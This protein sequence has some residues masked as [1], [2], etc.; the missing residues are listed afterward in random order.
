MEVKMENELIISQKI[1][2]VVFFTGGKIDPI[3]AEIEKKA[4]EIA[5]KGD[6]ATTSGRKVF[7]SAAYKVSRSKTLLDNMRKE[8][9]ADWKKKKEAVDKTWRGIEESLDDLRDRVR[10]P[11]TEWEAAE[12]A[13]EEKERIE[14]E[15]KEEQERIEA[16]LNRL[17]GIALIE[18]DLWKRQREIEAKEAEIKRIEDERKAKE[19]AARLAEERAIAEEAEA[20]AKAER[21]ERIR[22]EAEEKAKREAQE[23]LERAERA[24]AEAIEREKA[25]IMRAQVEAE[26]AEKRRI[27][28]EK[29]AKED[30]ERAIREAQEAERQRLEMIQRAKAAEEACKKA[31]AER[32]S[33]DKAHRAK[34]ENEAKKDLIALEFPLSDAELIVKAISEGK[35]RHVRI[36]Y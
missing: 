24:K 31:E 30:R 26:L 7:A 34:I 15:L 19:E 28:A 29:K 5:E 25:A 33:R 21:E 32:I 27:E 20:K 12:K 16:E 10:Q 18:H 2:P 6:L 13:R 23:A 9:V 14:R 4:F 11:L 17:H 36:E 8:L 3:L 1:D 35:I 22:K